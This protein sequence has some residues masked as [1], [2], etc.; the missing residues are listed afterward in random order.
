MRK[1][2]RELDVSGCCLADKVLKLMFNQTIKH[3]VTFNA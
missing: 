2:V 3:H 1:N